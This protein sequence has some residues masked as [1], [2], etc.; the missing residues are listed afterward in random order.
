MTSNF[1]HCSKKILAAE[2]LKILQL[3]YD[4]LQD[5][6]VDLTT[7]NFERISLRLGNMRG[8]SLEID[9]AQIETRTQLEVKQSYFKK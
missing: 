1:R 6:Y 7:Q 4:F 9:Y 5:E 8:G 2:R 3:H